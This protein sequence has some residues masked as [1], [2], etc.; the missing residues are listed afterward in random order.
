MLIFYGRFVSKWTSQYFTIWIMRWE[1][2]THMSITL[3]IGH[4]NQSWV[5]FV[6]FSASTRCRKLIGQCAIPKWIFCS[7]SAEKNS[8]KQSLTKFFVPIFIRPLIDCFYFTKKFRF[9]NSL[10]LELSLETSEKAARNDWTILKIMKRHQMIRE[11]VPPILIRI[12]L[13]ESRYRAQNE[14]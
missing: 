4:R 14:L 13:I 9:Q 12:A 7:V 8:H 2:R 10:R 6:S 5:L 11:F 3:F 1:E